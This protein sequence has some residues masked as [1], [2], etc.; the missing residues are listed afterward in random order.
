MSD[1]GLAGFVGWAIYVV[2]ALGLFYQVSAWMEYSSE[3]G[4]IEKLKRKL[5]GLL[6]QREAGGEVALSADELI[7]QEAV[8]ENSLTGTRTKEI[9]TFS[10]YPGMVA[11]HDLGAV[12]AET[13]AG[14]FRN[15]FPNVLIASLLVCGLLGTLWSLSTTLQ[16]EELTS[17][18]KKEGVASA[19][20]FQAALAPV[21]DGFGEAFEASIAGVLSTVVLI[22]VRIGV[23]VRREACF[24][25]LEHLVLEGLLPYFIEPEQDALRRAANLLEHQYLKSSKMVDDLESATGNLS[26]SVVAQQGVTEEAAVVFSKGGTVD[27]QFRQFTMETAALREAAEKICSSGEQTREVLERLTEENK[28][29]HKAVINHNLDM[30]D[31]Q[32][33]LVVE[34]QGS[35][36]ALSHQLSKYPDSVGRMLQLKESLMKEAR[37][38][39]SD[40]IA[41]FEKS[42]ESLKG[43]IALHPTEIKSSIEDLERAYE[44][45]FENLKKVGDSQVKGLGESAKVFN[46]RVEDSMATL[47]GRLAELPNQVQ[48]AISGEIGSV[49]TAIEALTAAS[50]NYSER[51]SQ[52][53]LSNQKVTEA[54]R[55][56]AQGLSGASARLTAP[57]IPASDVSSHEKRRRWNP[58]SRKER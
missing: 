25:A 42:L 35:I 54:L 10:K 24:G 27:Y 21:V 34:L 13:D 38:V 47:D 29:L 32:D 3:L 22:F 46:K 2:A 50:S 12:A 8:P 55:E 9:Q 51:F 28:K 16:S 48:N 11:L 17:F 41:G 30:A 56:A 57:P 58:F 33:M 4:H 40:Q 52:L 44:A 31:K 7:L 20:D 26:A 43:V 19:S 37:R 36:E 45:A 39:V 6:T 49:K 5:K 14:R 18:I 15:A 23:R 1:H 53:S